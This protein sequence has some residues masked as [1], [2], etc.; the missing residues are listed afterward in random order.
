[1]KFYVSIQHF[2]AL[3]YRLLSQYTAFVAVSE[4]VRV[5]PKNPKRQEVVPVPIPEG[6]N[7]QISSA[8]MPASADVPEPSQVL[9]TAAGFLLLGIG[10]SRK[11]RRG[12]F[13]VD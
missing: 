3:A 9:G 5:D 8:A 11:R 6:M 7:K 13:P 1:M 2:W 10:F 12:K 4:E